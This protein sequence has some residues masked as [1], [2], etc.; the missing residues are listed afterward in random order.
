MMLRNAIL[1]FLTV[2]SFLASAQ[3]GEALF[4]LAGQQRPDN[5]MRLLRASG[6]DYFIY[7]NASQ[8]LPLMDDFSIDRTRHKNAES[9]DPDVTFTDKVYFLEVSGISTPDMAFM[10][11]TTYYYTVDTVG[12][13]TIVRV[14]NP[15]TTVTQ[16]DLS[17][18]PSASTVITGWPPYDIWDTIGDPLSDT[19]LYAP[20]LTQDSL[21]VYTV[22]PSTATY[23][24]NNVDVP[25]VLWED[26]EVYVNGTYP[27]DPPTIGVATFDGVDRFGIPY[28]TNA[29]TAYGI[30]D[31]LTSVPINMLYPPGDSIYLSFFYQPQGLSGDSEVQEEDSLILEFYAPDEDEWMRVWRAPYTALTD[32]K[33]VMLPITDSRFLKSAFQMRFLN[34]GTQSGALDHWHLDYVRLGRQRSVSDTVLVDVAYLY[35]EASLLQTYTSVPFAHFTQ[36]PASYMASSVTLMQ[37][38]LDVS[39]H[40][41][42]WGVRSGLEGAAPLANFGTGN[43]I[44]NNASSTYPSV[45]QVAPF[46]YDPGLS[47]GAAFWRNTFWANTTPDMNR[48]NDTTTFVQELSNYYAYDDGS[49][50]AGYGLVNAPNGK[51]AVRFDMQIGDTL[52]AVRI[53]FDPIFYPENPDAAPFLLTVWNSVIPESIRFQNI[54]YSDPEYRPHGLNKFV[55]YPL[56][57]PI[58]V[59]PT[60]YVGLVQTD[61]TFLNIGFDKNRDNSNKLFYDTDGFFEP[62]SQVGSLMLRPVFVSDVD[63]FLGMEEPTVPQLA[64]APNPASDRFQLIGLPEGA[65]TVEVMDAM[66]RTVLHGSLR[67]GS[68]IDVTKVAPGPYHVR[69]KGP[70]G[71]V[72]GTGRLIVQR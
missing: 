65:S 17:D 3:S 62:T 7:E 66:G 40:L 53:Y 15:E 51:V 14:A 8:E 45:H 9:T 31:H 23:D 11:D 56:D 16:Y 34:Y 50:E 48:Y 12:V 25:L 32:F 30:N 2:S 72:I 5:P 38:N 20:D 29:P 63:P 60:F 36:A 18:Y 57:Q 70:S 28:V 43:N 68:S 41:I 55:E 71:S 33:Q 64:L 13:D 42:T 24:Q 21:M 1:L 59:P 54:S 58:Y 22:A 27:I 4:P 39:D 67:N 46:A 61:P 69:A 47:T 26:D 10:T 37:K 6:G 19:I 44:I 49:A 35:P 52:R